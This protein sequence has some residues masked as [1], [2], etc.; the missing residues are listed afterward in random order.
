MAKIIDGKKV[1]AAVRAQ[2]RDEVV[3]L[4]KRGVQPGLAVVIVGNDPASRTYVN[5]KKKA[6]AD[7]GI[8]SEEYALP[9]TTTQEE[10]LALVDQLNHKK[11]IN[12]ILVQSPLPRGLDE[13]AVV[14]AIA[15]EKD[16]DAFHPDNV[17]RIMIGNYHFLPCTPAGVIELLQSEQ[18]EIAG[19]NCVVIGRSNI[20]GKPMAMLL[21]HHNGTVTICHSRTKDLKAVCRQADILVSAVGKAG[22][23][24]ADMVKPGAAVIDVGMNRNSEGKLCGDVDYAA[25]EKLAGYIT[26]VPGGVGPMTIAMLLR[27]TLTAA[28]LQNNQ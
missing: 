15:P 9:E 22:F 10:L 2:V 20:V 4:V 12:G 28:K 1:S 21:L 14:E 24:T 3:E 6:C 8:Y 19:K 18:I 26:P 23:V 11:E 27:N 5:N 17:G 25:V 7:T 13:E 16:V